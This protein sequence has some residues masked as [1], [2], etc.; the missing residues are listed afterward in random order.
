M[1]D[2]FEWIEINNV[3]WGIGSG[4]VED[5]VEGVVSSWVVLWITSQTVGN[6]WMSC[7]LIP[8]LI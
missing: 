7:S 8:M 5:E 2:F 4:G 3:I 6:R 1:K